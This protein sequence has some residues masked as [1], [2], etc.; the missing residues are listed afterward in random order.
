MTTSFF[1]T[2]IVRWIA[3]IW[4]V[5]SFLFNQ[6]HLGLAGDQLKALELLRPE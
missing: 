6:S 3:R 4:S 5:L 1:A 2:I